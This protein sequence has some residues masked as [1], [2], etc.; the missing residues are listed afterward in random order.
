MKLTE[1]ILQ[2]NRMEKEKRFYQR[3][4]KNTE[5]LTT[6]LMDNLESTLK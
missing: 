5:Q 3:S 2:C 6:A 4:V 1:F